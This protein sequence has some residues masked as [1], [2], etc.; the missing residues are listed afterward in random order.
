MNEVVRLRYGKAL[1]T[2]ARTP[3]HI[4]VYGSNGV[5][6]WH[7][8]ALAHGPTVV[9]G[10]KGQG[11]L[12]VEWCSG[13]FWVI[14]T[15]YYVEFSNERLL[16]RFFYY[17]TKYVGLN[18]L[19]DGTSNPSLTRATFGIQQIPTPPLPEQRAIA[20]IL[21][22]LDDKIELNRKMNRTLEALARAIFK[23][24]FVDFD[25][26]RAK[27]EGRPPPGMDAET[28]A[29]FPDGF[30]DSELGPIPRGW[31]VQSLDEIAHFLNG[32]ACQRF[33]PDGNEATLPVIKIRELNQGITDRTDRARAS[34]PEKWHVH[35]GDV[36]FSWS[37][38]LVVKVWTG[39]P[40]ALNQHLFKVTSQSF[41]RWFYLSWVQH[42]LDTFR[43]I[44]R[45]KATTMGHIKRHHL[46]DAKCAV[47]SRAVLAAADE[48]L[49]P[50]IKRQVVNDLESRTLAALRDTLLPKLVSGELRVPDPE[51]F[52]Q[53]VAP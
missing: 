6:G 27:A 48:V 21:G 10:R 53:E 31:R 13:P 49:A 26:V 37:G 12:G 32:A 16:P 17:F 19:K 28:A 29:L 45:D 1:T 3:G 15:A 40:G 30:E 22:S 46:T 2:S 9:L 23:S 25:P 18:H 47:P 5:T 39:G 50:L 4:P 36:I 33:R 38:S 44:A 41:P 42:H 43:G 14:D 52:L 34:I 35:D 7:N 8:V 51:R 20:H 24:W 11:P